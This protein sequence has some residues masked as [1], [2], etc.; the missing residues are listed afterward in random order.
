MEELDADNQRL[1]F[2]GRF[3]ERDIVQVSSKAADEDNCTADECHCT[4]NAEVNSNNQSFKTAAQSCPVQ[5]SPLQR[6]LN[7]IVLSFFC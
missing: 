3:A 2:Q 4:W 5:S 1:S 7:A 6:S